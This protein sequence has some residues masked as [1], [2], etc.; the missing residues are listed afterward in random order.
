VLAQ[1][2]GVDISLEAVGGILM[3]IL[4]PIAWVRNISK[5]SF[6]FLVGN[7][8]IMTTVIIV[9]VVLIH[10]FINREPGNRFGPEIVPLN[11]ESYWSMIGFSCYAYEGIGVVMPIM[12]ACDCPEKFDK[13]LFYA[14][15]TLTVVYC[16]FADICYLILGKELDTTFI[17][18]ELNQG[19]SVVILLQVIYSINLVCS[20]PIM[21]YPANTIIE[22]YT[23]RSLSKRPDA[24]SK[25]IYHWL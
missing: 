9:S 6:T 1:V 5:F 17:T 18:Q 25:K 13:I 20:Y 12:S 22:D 15:L 24:K 4:I 2:W 10:K 3:L 8:L 19:S 16:S 11:F 23:L 14:I 7:T 21:I